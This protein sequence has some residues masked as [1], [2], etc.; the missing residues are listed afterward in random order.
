[1]TPPVS[2]YILHSTA[3]H[4]LP[5]V[6]SLADAPSQIIPAESNG[7]DAINFRT[8]RESKSV[9]FTSEPVGTSPR[10]GKPVGM[11]DII[12]AM[13]GSPSAYIGGNSTP[14]MLTPKELTGQYDATPSASTTGDH[15]S[16]FENEPN[17]FN[18]FSSVTRDVGDW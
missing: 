1:M 13:A 8:L 7:I 4:K 5:V 12:H 2:L 6:D 9:D 16:G 3:R 10:S 15:T 18:E 14:G 17:P 11:E